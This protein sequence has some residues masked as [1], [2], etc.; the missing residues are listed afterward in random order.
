VRYLVSAP[1]EITVEEFDHATGIV[2]ED[3]SGVR[4]LIWLYADVTH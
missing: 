3:A 4:T 1:R 2:V